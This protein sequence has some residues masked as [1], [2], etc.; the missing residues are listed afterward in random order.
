MAIGQAGS[1][2]TSSP[3]ENEP[4]TIT[5]DQPLSDPVIALTAT[6]NGG[7]QFV[8]RVT[9]MVTDANGDVI[10]F[11]FIIE[12]WE[13]HDGPHPATETINWIAVEE[14]V[15][16]LPDGRVIEAGTVSTTS[17]TTSAS[18]NGAFADPPVVLTSVMSNNDTTTVDGDPLNISSA[19][20]D[21]RLQEEEAEA[22]NHGPETIGYIAIQSGGD[23][24]SGTAQT[25]GGFDESVGTYGL[26]ATFS[27]AIVLGETQTIN[28]GDTATV[29]IDSL[30]SSSVDMF[31][32][33][34]QSN[35]GEMGHVDETLGVVAF[36]EGLILCFTPGAMIETVHGPLPVEAL[37]PGVNVLTQDNGPQPLRWVARTH[38]PH[39]RL[40][41]S[42]KLRP[43]LVTRGALGPGVPASDIVVSPQHR[44]LMTGWRT[45]MM[46]GLSEALIPARALVNGRT[47]RWADT[48]QGI[49]YIHLLFDRH[50]IVTA[51]GTA[52]ESLH[53][54]QLDRSE[55]APAAREELHMLFPD[56]RWS[57]GSYGDLARPALKMREAALLRA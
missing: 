56:L 12:E 38:L 14:G 24:T 49:S 40:A 25:F 44:M 23:A 19:G 30:T 43:V 2:T 32:E 11:T 20:F 53:P 22:N 27:N 57:V 52:S 33:E 41:A 29:V 51:N 8:L 36:E 6:N 3:T 54:G 47:I 35:D 1:I 7:N 16:T 9:D 21:I 48:A 10:E 45:E 46:F 13:Y 39:S 50:E 42:P 31:L 18:L 37:T 55:L 26:G 4:I 34:E 17:N 5:L 28:G 15:H